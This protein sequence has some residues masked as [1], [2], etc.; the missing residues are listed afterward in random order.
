[1]KSWSELCGQMQQVSSRS[2]GVSELAGWRADAID[3]GF[4]ASRAGN[5]GER[6]KSRVS[7]QKLLLLPKKPELLGK[8]PQGLNRL[9]NKAS[10][11][12]RTREKYPSVAEATLIMLALCGG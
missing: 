5:A 9:R 3:T 7:A 8:A 4:I 1:M 11:L 10:F 2:S 6:P 12:S